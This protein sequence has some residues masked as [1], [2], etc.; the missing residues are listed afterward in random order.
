MKKFELMFSD[1]SS[2]DLEIRPLTVLD[3]FFIW[4]LHMVYFQ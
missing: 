3:V 2:E 1:L 4:I